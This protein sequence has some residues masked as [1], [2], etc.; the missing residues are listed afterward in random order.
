MKNRFNRQIFSL[1]LVTCLM[2]SASM[3]Q[4]PTG[5]GLEITGIKALPFLLE[6]NKV[7]FQPILIKANLS[8]DSCIV[9]VHV[10][11][12]EP[13]TFVFKKGVDSLEIPV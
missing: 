12:N 13:F 3:A 11:G 6:K 10:D 7:E 2:I 1:L 9:I 8:A 5:S 4:Q